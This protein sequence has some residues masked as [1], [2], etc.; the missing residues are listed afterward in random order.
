VDLLLDPHPD[1]GG[2]DLPTMPKNL[3]LA[4]VGASADDGATLF[5]RAKG[6]LEALRR[7]CFLD[8]LAL[9]GQSEALWA[10]RSAR[11]GIRV[12]THQA[13]TL[14]LLQPRLLRRAGIQGVHVAYAELDITPLTAKASRE[15]LFQALAE[16]P[17]SDFDLSVLLAEDIAWARVEA[18]VGTG[19]KLVES[20]TYVGEY[21]SAE[22]GEGFRSLTL[23]VRL[24]P[25][26][27]TLTRDDILRVRT[28]ILHALEKEFGAKLR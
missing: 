11:L 15:N 13:G 3:A 6:H 25:H 12:G 24:Q 16:L 9:E 21:R 20:V 22:L 7:H 5:R 14:A 2:E 17:A 28:D 10:D 4:L 27:M 1:G 26:E 19:N 23:R 18:V 8:D